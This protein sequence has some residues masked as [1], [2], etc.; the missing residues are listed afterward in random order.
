[1]EPDIQSIL[2]NSSTIAVYGMSRDSWKPAHTVPGYMLNQGYIVIPINPF[3]DKIFGRTSYPD[4]KSVPQD[5]DLLNVFR[6]SD[7]VVPVV[8]EAIE[9]RKERGDIHAIWLQLGIVNDEAKKLAEE[10]GIVFVQNRCIYV[11]HKRSG[12]LRRKRNGESET[13]YEK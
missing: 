12:L 6:P 2:E 5:I 10:A 4:I 3:T 13:S 11:D 7:Q 8:E 1:M 9:R